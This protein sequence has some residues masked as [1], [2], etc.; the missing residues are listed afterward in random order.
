MINDEQQMPGFG[1]N[2]NLKPCNFPVQYTAEQLSEYGKCAEDPVYF[3]DTYCTIITLD[4]GLQ[5]FKLYDCQKKKVK[6]IHENR[7]VLLM[8]GRQ[9][10]KC[11]V[12]DTKYKVRNKKTGEILYVTAEQ[13]HQMQK[14]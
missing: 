2:P 1:G 9:Q 3:I 14:T 8:E 4:G 13:F 5:P 6:F 11:F 10:G 7:K 12:K